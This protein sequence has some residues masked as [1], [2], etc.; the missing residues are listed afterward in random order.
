M[1]KL[2]THFKKYKGEAYTEN[3]DSSK[4]H[5]FHF[6]KTSLLLVFIATE[7]PKLRMKLIAP[8]ICFLVANE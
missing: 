8:N 4:N 5:L 1:T 7:C 3:M 6:R 2:H